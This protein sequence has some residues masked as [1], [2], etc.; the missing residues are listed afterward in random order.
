MIPKGIWLSRGSDSPGACNRSPRLKE[1]LQHE[2]GSLRLLPSLIVYRGWESRGILAW[3]GLPKSRP[4]INGD[5]FACGLAQQQGDAPGVFVGHPA[6]SA[7]GNYYY[8]VR[9][10]RTAP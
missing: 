5:A 7:Q 4:A 1:R 9:L 2:E 8:F 3:T 6:M 10:I